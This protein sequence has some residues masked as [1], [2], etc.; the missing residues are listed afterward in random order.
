MDQSEEGFVKLISSIQDGVLEADLSEQLTEIVSELTAQARDM[1][2]KPKA[3]LTLNLLFKLDS[4][5]V[6][7][8]ADVKVTQPKPV[9]GKSIF[10]PTKD[11][12]LSPENPRQLEMPLRDVATEGVSDIRARL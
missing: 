3:K 8:T 7:V 12:Q 9:L 1:G 2:G 4:G 11:N 10:W 5:M 6:E